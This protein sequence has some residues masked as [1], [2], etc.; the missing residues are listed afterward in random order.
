MNGQPMP[1]ARYIVIEEHPEGSYLFRYSVDWKFSGD[2][3]HES[4]GDLLGQVEWEFGTKE[5]EWTPISETELI[6]FTS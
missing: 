6:K 2:T 5:L 3:W 4:L 1:P